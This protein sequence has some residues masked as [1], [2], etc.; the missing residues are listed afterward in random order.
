[1]E[2]LAQDTLGFLSAAMALMLYAHELLGAGRWRSAVLAGL[3]AGVLMAR[4]PTYYQPFAIVLGLPVLA[5]TVAV[6]LARDGPLRPKLTALAI[7]GG[8]GAVLA[9]G[10]LWEARDAIR[11]LRETVYP[12]H[13]V[14]T[15]AHLPFGKVFGATNLGFLDH[16]QSDVVG[17][18]ASE[19]S[20]AFTVLFLVAL[21]I[22]SAGRWNGTRSGQAAWWMLSGF[23]AFWLIWC[24]V[25]LG[26]FGEHLPIANLVPAFRAANTVGFL[27]ILAFCLVMA[28]WDPGAAVARRTALGCSVGVAAVSVGSGRSLQHVTLPLLSD[29]DIW[30]SAVGAGAVVLALVWW[31]GRAAPAAVAILAV[32]ALTATTNPVVV[33]LADYRG[34]GAARVMLAA[35]EQ[36]RAARTLWATD[37]PELDGLLLATGTPSL[38]SRQIM[39]P[40]R[41][42]WLKFDP[43]GTHEKLWNR[44]G[45]FPHFYWTDR[46]GIEWSGSSAPNHV[47][48]N[49]SPCTA[50]AIEP[51]L[52][53]VVAGKPLEFTC[54]SYQ[55]TLTWNGRKQFVYDVR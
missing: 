16:V 41:A 47:V 12:G 29:A 11:A 54:L 5:A 7:A 14:N 33:G 48:L 18:N 38:S 24:T 53:H 43:G 6:L 32:A 8:S 30:L 17:T 26:G 45:A 1:V 9:A 34:S 36:A 28:Q 15:G 44:G 42:E 13:R 4:Y 23:T 20:S 21:V 49:L 55:R 27:A 39:G 10:T 2:Q 3:L 37:N 22:R 40:N 35:G 51:R 25:D 52:K 50:A 31:P 19:I 46:A